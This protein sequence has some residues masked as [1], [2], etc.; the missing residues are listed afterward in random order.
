MIPTVE[1]LQDPAAPVI[2]SVRLVHANDAVIVLMVDLVAKRA[3]ACGGSSGEGWEE[4]YF[5]GHPDSE[6]RDR[7]AVLR[8]K[9]WDDPIVA[10]SKTGRYSMWVTIMRRG[11]AGDIL[12]EGS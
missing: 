8:I 3:E 12:W 9:V 6:Y 1:V 2:G 7:H 10:S 11:P 4:V 5:F